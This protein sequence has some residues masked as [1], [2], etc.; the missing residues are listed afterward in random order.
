MFINLH[1]HHKS[2]KAVLNVYPKETVPNSWFSMGIHPWFLD[3]WREQLVLLEEKIKDV[4]CLGIG[5]CGLDRICESDRNDQEECFKAQ[6]DLANKHYKPLIIHC[7]KSFD[8]LAKVFKEVSPRVPVIIHG[9][10]QKIDVLPKLDNLYLSLGY[11]LLKDG[12]NVQS[13]VQAYSLEKIFFETDDREDLLIEEVYQKAAQ[14]LNLPL[15]KIENQIIEN[16]K[17]VFNVKI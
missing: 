12:S 13:S 1:T 7:V 11:G 17:D 8:W 9:F 2:D 4:N 16:F 15:E 5:E 14:L 3:D 10:N 6:I